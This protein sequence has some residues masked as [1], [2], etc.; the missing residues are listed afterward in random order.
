MVSRWKPALDSFILLFEVHT[1]CRNDSAYNFKYS[2]RKADSIVA[3]MK[4]KCHDSI[5][6]IGIGMGESQPVNHCK[7]EGEIKVPC[8]EESHQ[9]NRRI[10]F[11]IIGRREF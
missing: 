4:R 5:A 10:V 9:E 7:C 8:S 2:Q 11:K 3:Y 1:D 6:V